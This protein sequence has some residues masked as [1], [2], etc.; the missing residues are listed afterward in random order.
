MHLTR[1]Q[2]QKRQTLGEF[3]TEAAQSAEPVSQQG[4]Q[5]MLDLLARLRALPDERR[6]YGSTSLYRPC[7]LAEDTWKSPWL[8]IVVALDK[9]SYT[10]EY[11]MPEAI[12]PWP[13]AYIRGEARSEDEAVRLIQIAMEKSEGWNHRP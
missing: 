4:G 9:R 7:L 10:V 11:L 8:V 2:D 13:H 5:A 1:C 12:A 3:Y 6:V